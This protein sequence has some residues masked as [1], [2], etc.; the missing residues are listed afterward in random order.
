MAK[1]KVYAVKK[2]KQTGLLTLFYSINFFLCHV[3]SFK[4]WDY[5]IIQP[6]RQE[7]YVYTL[8]IFVYLATF[9]FCFLFYYTC[10]VKTSQCISLLQ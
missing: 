3:Y 8:T 2:G 1:K 4:I 7:F 5:S 10:S 6:V 9:I